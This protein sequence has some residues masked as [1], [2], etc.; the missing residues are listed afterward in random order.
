MEAGGEIRFDTGV[1]LVTRSSRSRSD[2]RAKRPYSALRLP[3]CATKGILHSARNLA[4]RGLSIREYGGGGGNRTPVRRYF[5]KGAYVR[6]PPFCS[7]TRRLQRTRSVECQPLRSR[8]DRRGPRPRP[9]RFVVAL[10]SPYGRGAVRTSLPSRQR[11]ATAQW[12]LFVP[13]C[14]TSQRDLGTQPEP[15]LPPSKPIAPTEGLPA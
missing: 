7:R 5:G 6:S 11:E 4:V 12:Q 8:P 14:F 3:P 1:W 10:N 2:R 15:R 13:A 9:A